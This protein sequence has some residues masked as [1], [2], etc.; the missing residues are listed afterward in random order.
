MSGPVVLA[1]VLCACH[2]DKATVVPP[3]RVEV[4]A[5]SSAAANTGG[6]VFSGT[7]ESA[8]ASTVS[9]S[10]P[11]TITKIYVDEGQKVT[12]GQVLA[13]VKSESLENASNIAAAELEEA[14]DAYNRLKKLHDANAL[15]DIKW[16]EVQSKL[17]QAENAAALA[18]RAVSDATL[19]SPM[20]GYVA[21]KLADDGQTVIAAQPVLKIVDL[22]RLQVSIS[23]PENEITS[24]SAGTVA[25]IT[26]AG[27]DSMR[28]TGKLG[29]KGVVANPLTRTYN[30]KFDLPDTRGKVL[31][32]M[33]AAV[34][35]EGVTPDSSAEASAPVTLPSQA[36]L[37]AAD[38]RLFVWV[39]KDGKARQRFVTADEL[40]TDGV[41]V[42]TGIA[43]GDSVIVAGMQKVSNGT[44]VTVPE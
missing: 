34:D 36:V 24:F 11:G 3:V 14:R 44:E 20:S 12:R 6:Q 29:R 13:R 28:I 19:T 22:D 8:D 1:G 31:P 21:E 32:G 25:K 2:H 35:V 18:R 38:N 5:V 41:R 9:F 30:V 23:V 10:V 39:V 37:L 42:H 43:P 27:A 40:S 17:K 16:V 4:M 7:V 15:P 33:I 26:V